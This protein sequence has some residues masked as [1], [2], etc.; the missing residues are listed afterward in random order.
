[1]AMGATLQIINSTG[2]AIMFTGI[3]QVNDDATWS[4]VPPAGTQIPNGQ[5]VVIGM[6]NSSVFF[7]PR[8]VGAS[9]VFV[10]QSNFAA[11]E[12]DFDDP[13]IGAHSFNFGNTAVFDY[14]VTNPSG[15]TYVVQIS[16]V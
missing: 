16:L 2:S 12:I 10:C 6:A 9:C 8:G 3:N 7:A 15:N 14:T 11:G 1:M 5:S 13:A 4:V